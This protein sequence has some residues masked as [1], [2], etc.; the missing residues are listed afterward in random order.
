MTLTLRPYQTQLIDDIRAKWDSGAQ[1]VLAVMP[2]GA[3]KTVA[4]SKLNADG[5]RSCTIVHRQELVGQ[6]SRTYALTGI[7][8][9][10]IAPQS[11]INYCI[12]Q[13]VKTTGR[14]FYDPRASVSVAGVD[15][16][17]RRFKPGDPWCNSIRRWT[18]DE[19]A[20]L[21]Q[22]NKWGKAVA[23]FP[24]AKGLGVTATP[25]RADKKSLHADQHGVFHAMVQGPGMRD[26][27]GI[28]M[29]CEYRVIASQTGIDEAL[30]RIGST[31][32]FTSA[33]TKAARKS[34]I[35]GDVVETY[36]RHVPGRQAIVF[37]VDVQDARDIAD[38]FVAE[39]IRAASLDATSNDSLRQSQFDQFAAGELQVLTNVNLFAEG[40]DVPSCDVVIMARPTASFGLFCQQFAR[41]LTPAP[42]KDCIARGSLVLTDTGLKPIENISLRDMVWD[43]CNFVSHGGAVCKGT[44]NVI[45]YA[46]LDATPDHLV[47]TKK[48]WRTLGDC[49]LEQIEIAQTGSGGTPIRLR[50]NLFSGGSLE[51][52][53]AQ[54]NVRE[55]RMRHVWSNLRASLHK[56][57]RCSH[58]GLSK[59][60]PTCAFST[61]DLQESTRTGTA[62]YKLKRPCVQ[63]LWGSWHRVSVFFGFGRCLVGK[64][65]SRRSQRQVATSGQN[66][67]RRTLRAGKYSMVHIVAEQFACQETSVQRSIAPIST[68]SPGDSVCGLNAEEVLFKTDDVRADNRAVLY[69]VE[70]TQR[71]VWDILNAGP[72]HRFTAQGLLVHNCGIII[73]HVGNV[74]RMAAK[75]GLPDTPRTWTLWQDETRKANG[76]P[77]AVP[78]RVCPSCLLTY[79]A[80]VFACPYC[81]ADHVPAGRSSP[82][83]VDGVLSEM[84]LELLA[85]LRAGA[86][87]IQAAEPA[88]PYGASEIVAAGIRARHRRNQAAQASLSDAMQRWGGMRLAAGDSDEVMQSRFLYRFGTDV[89]S[90]QGL[91]ERAALE[92]RDEINVA[93]QQKDAGQ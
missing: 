17:I 64:T 14:N 50:K 32:D 80:V 16:L 76:N 62:L 70:Q 3:G 69:S 61:L 90:A 91:S 6:I 71:E 85:T 75:H 35:I 39:G 65:A 67:E 86:A 89:M 55:D 51:G 81:G 88:I 57:K 34:E 2:T 53:S 66:R 59:L 72:L 46:G 44:K 19:A 58:E 38:R 79:E 41:C 47:W 18:T 93:L 82:D 28:G 87:K 48:G 24:N 60:Q 30:L 1:N 27:I 25:I 84:S 45:S 8:H 7:Y 22:E 10:I 43:G 40:V 54:P 9:N 42:G 36:Q 37:A 4:F 12:S 21:L 73:D 13:H 20:H 29:V 56:L 77:D 15:T 68:R 63:K 31:G 33:S 74:V 49:A 83:Q 26:L 52:A 11:V 23:L 92:L 5:E 78:V